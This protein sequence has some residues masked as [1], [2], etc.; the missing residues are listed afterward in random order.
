M[1]LDTTNILMQEK[2]ILEN[3]LK[4]LLP[5]WELAEWFLVLV[6]ATDNQNFIDGIWK[7]L[8]KAIKSIHDENKK[9]QIKKQLIKIKKLRSQ[10]QEDHTKDVKIADA[11]LDD[12]INSLE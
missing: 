6:Q 2:Q 12:L 7:L 8:V 4:R 5:Y 10:D 9:V 11:M 1:N 3:L